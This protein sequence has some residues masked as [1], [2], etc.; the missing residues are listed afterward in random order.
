MHYINITILS[1]FCFIL[2]S[3]FVY[4]Y[5]VKK[6]DIMSYLRS[7]GHQDITVDKDGDITVRITAGPK[8][9]KV[10]II[11]KKTGKRAWAIKTM[12]IVPV[13]ITHDKVD[14]MIRLAN[15]F[16]RR[17][18]LFRTSYVKK[19]RNRYKMIMKSWFPCEYVKDDAKETMLKE[20]YANSFD[21]LVSQLKTIHSASKCVLDNSTEKN[22]KTCLEEFGLSNGF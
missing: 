17:K 20:Y 4:P 12:H 13:R 15:V 5:E 9:F 2:S 3:G 21:L 18:G 19:K 11:I 1:I 7:K 14:F 6:N 16:N 22:I 8:D 10:N